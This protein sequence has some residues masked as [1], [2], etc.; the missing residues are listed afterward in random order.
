MWRAVPQVATLLTFATASLA[1]LVIP[2][3]AVLYVVNRSVSDGRRVGLAAVVGL[4]VGSMVHVLAAAVGLSAV[5]AASAVGFTMV[6]WLGVGYLVWIG[7]RTMT[8]PAVALSRDI[9]R[10]SRRRALRQGAVVNAL[11]VK[12][13][14]FF[15][16]FLP[17]FLDPGRGWVGV[18]AL[19]LGLVFVTIALCTDSAYA[20]LAS[21]LREALL[22]GR[23]LAFVQRWVAGAIYIGLGLLAATTDPARSATP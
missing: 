19:V 18:Q 22:R 10:T 2:G 3:P 9:A 16:S 23:S 21:G 13:A 11:N 7:V 5:I 8:L 6:K 17:Q 12:I 1:L 4:Q 14:L 15:L 20:L